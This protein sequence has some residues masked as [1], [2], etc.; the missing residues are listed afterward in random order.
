MQGLLKSCPSI[1]EL[2]CEECDQLQD[3]SFV[4]HLGFK[5]IGCNLTSV[6]VSGC[7]KI[8]STFVRC[9]TDVTRTKLKAINLSW[10]NVDCISLLYLAG[11]TLTTAVQIAHLSKSIES[12]VLKDIELAKNLDINA[13]EK[14]DELNK[15]ERLLTPIEEEKSASGYLKE[16]CAYCTEEVRLRN[17]SMSIFGSITEE[18]YDDYDIIESL[19]IAEDPFEEND[20]AISMNDDIIEWDVLSLED[21]K[22]IPNTC[23]CTQKSPKLTATE[24]ESIV[25]DTIEA[26]S[27]VSDS[28]N[29]KTKE[30]EN[31]MHAVEGSSYKQLFQP[32][33]T[34]LDITQIDFYDFEVGKRCIE[35]FTQSNSCLLHL[36]MSWSRLDN[37]ILGCIANNE[38]NLRSL[39]LVGF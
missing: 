10:T 15:V 30:S 27:S 19:T 5:N 8:S 14:Q 22:F 18:S 26:S 39:S 38:I 3:S 9:L 13:S 20:K 34:S 4:K 7:Q 35:L 1:E 36:H 23:E 37:G 32:N 6:N 33:I 31:M 16:L 21:I 29:M 17:K 12:H 25:D 28:Q 24:L 2:I 11:F